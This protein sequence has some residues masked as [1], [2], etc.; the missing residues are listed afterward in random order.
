METAEQTSGYSLKETI[1]A[2]A[3]S[4][5]NFIEFVEQAL[6]G[7]VA[8][9]EAGLTHGQ[10]RPEHLVLRW[11]RRD[12]VRVTW[13]HFE[14]T[15]ESLGAGADLYAFGEVCYFALTQRGLSTSVP[16]NLGR[17]RPDLGMALTDWV[18]SLF[19][20][21]PDRRPLTARSALRDFRRAIARTLP[22]PVAPPAPQVVA[23]PL[24][25]YPITG[26]WSLSR[27]LGNMVGAVTL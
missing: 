19:A 21:N 23:R 20:S 18:T 6:D 27:V 24:D 2:A 3:F 11:D 5:R 8:A 22:A 13:C 14:R 25:H 9:H 15:P 10:I 12:R 4:R 16:A 26:W 7:L 1:D 17:L